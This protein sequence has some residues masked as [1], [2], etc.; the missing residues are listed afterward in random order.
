[1]KSML[2]LGI[3]AVSLICSAS[4][5][6][7]ADIAATQKRQMQT[8]DNGCCKEEKSCCPQVKK[9][10]ECEEVVTPCPPCCPEA[11]CCGQNPCYPKC[12]PKPCGPKCDMP[13]DGN[14]KM[15]KKSK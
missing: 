11:D 3:L 13:C 5:F 7:D 8:A 15:Q 12:E 14:Q 4:A 1:M 6:A 9:K 2:K 10:V